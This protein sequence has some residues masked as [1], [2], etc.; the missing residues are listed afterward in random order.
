MGKLRQPKRQSGSRIKDRGSSAS[1]IPSEQLPPVF[2]FQFQRQGWTIG[3]CNDGSKVK[4]ADAIHVRSR[5]TWLQIENASH[6]GFG[7]EKIPLAKIRPDIPDSFP[8]E[9]DKALILRCGSGLMR[10]AGFRSQRIFHIVWVDP[11]GSP[12][13]H[14][15]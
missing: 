7:S 14:G 10:L 13:D 15:E 6:K 4:L 3:N 12:Y 5:M 8:K 11:D 1:D 2:C 9:I